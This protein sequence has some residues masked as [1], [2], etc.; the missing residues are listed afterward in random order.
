MAHCGSLGSGVDIDS[1]QKQR[2]SNFALFLRM[3]DEQRYAGLLYGEISALL[4]YNRFDG[5]LQTLLEREDLHHRLVNGSDY[6]LPAVN[7]V[8]RTGDLKEAGFITDVERDSLNKI[9]RYNPLLFD[10][11]LKRTVRHPQSGRRFHPRVF[12]SPFQLDGI[13]FDGNPPGDATV[14]SSRTHR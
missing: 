1:P 10:F 2:V 3:M 8:I 7:V 4:Q 5:P 11:V 6:P 14:H 13:L 12:T 9:Y